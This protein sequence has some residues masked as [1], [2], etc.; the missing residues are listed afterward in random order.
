MTP[1]AGNGSD[2]PLVDLRRRGQF[3]FGG[4]LWAAAGGLLIVAC[5]GALVIYHYAI[6]LA[7]RARLALGFVPPTRG[8]DWFILIALSLGPVIGVV[9]LLLFARWYRR[10]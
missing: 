3:L 1:D 4:L 10:L 9:A 7:E 2:S 6:S 8:P 5:S